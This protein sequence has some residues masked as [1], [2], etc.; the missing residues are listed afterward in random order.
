MGRH[1]RTF[2]ADER[3]LESAEWAVILGLIA[4]AALAAVLWLG[5]RV[6]REFASLRAE[7][8]GD[9]P[10]VTVETRGP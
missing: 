9:R 7:I 4:A 8:T 2:R 1:L 3:G 5:P 10:A 6:A